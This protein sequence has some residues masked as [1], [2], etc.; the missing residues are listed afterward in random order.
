M[1]LRLADR[2]IWDFWTVSV[3]DELHVF[4]LQAPRALGDPEL[5]HWNVTIGHAVSSDLS[6]WE[7]LPDALAPG[8]S[9]AFDDRSTWTGSVIVH[10][11]LWH[12]LYTGTSSAEDGLVQRVGLATSADLTTWTRRPD[13]VLEA[14]PRW[15]EL[16]DRDA[17]HD[18]AWRDPWLFR[19]PGDAAVHAYV[20]ARAND[21]EPR[22]RGVIGH[23]RSR[24]LIHWEVL[25]PV[26]EPM[27][28]GQMEVPQLIEAGGRF[29]L[30]FSS[31]PGTR[32]DALDLRGSGTYSLSG[33]TPFG[34]FHP[35]SL[36]ELDA[37]PH[38]ATYAGRI[39][40]HRGGLWFLAWIGY[41]D[42]GVFAGELAPPRAV[43]VHAGG[44]LTLEAAR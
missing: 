5:R 18:Q 23:A 35:A 24:D 39:V 26:T 41:R 8:A 3:G 22:G 38:H 34:P 28:F 42:D 27:G 30:L 4:S 44:G 15:Y 40:P 9:G 25:P 17:W 19:V 13:P 33:P 12:M 14:D 16:L 29:H 36:R 43:V 20:T 6:N 7:V 2:W 11:G 1:T 21:G 10:D 32:S 31:D 37:G